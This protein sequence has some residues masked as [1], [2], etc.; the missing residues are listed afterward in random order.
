MRDDHRT[1]DREEEETCVGE[2]E[3]EVHQVRVRVRV[4]SPVPPLHR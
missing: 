4:I 3:E 1:H 2:K